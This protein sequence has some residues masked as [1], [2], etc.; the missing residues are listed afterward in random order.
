[1]RSTLALVLMA[2]AA[3][4]DG[5]LVDRRE[6]PMT[7]SFAV[8][9]HFVR[10]SIDEQ[11]AITEV[12]QVLRN[13]SGHPAEAVYL[14]PVPHGA[15]ITGFEMWVGDRKMDGEIM[16]AAK[17]RELYHSFVRTKRDPALLEYVGQGVYRTSVFPVGVDEEKRLRI[18]YTELLKKENGLVRYLYPLNTEKF[19]KFPLEEAKVEVTIKSKGKIKTVYSPSHT[20]DLQRASETSARAAWSVRRDTPRTDFE[21]LYSTDES[22]VG[23]NLLTYRP[24][25]DEPGYFL[26]LASPAATLEGPVE[27][28]DIVFVL[29]KSG[30]MRADN[31]MGQAKEA[32]TFCLRSLND[33]DRF[34]IVSFSSGVDKYTEKLISFNEAEKEKATQH[35]SRI[36]VQGGTNINDA[37]VQALT[38]FEKGERLKMIIFLTDGLPTNGV[39]DVQ[40]IVKNV[41]AANALSVR[42]FNFGV[43]YDVNTT[44]LD[45]L[46]RENKGDSDY[47]K[48][49]ENIEEK[50]SAFYTKVQSP[51]LSS[52]KLDWGGVKVKDVLPRTIPDLFKGGQVVVT[53]RYEGAGPQM[54][55]L[56]GMSRGKE[57]R[58]EVE[59]TFDA[60]SDGLAKFFIERLWA[61]RKIG[62]IIDQIQL[63]GKAQEL[64][65]EIVR[66]SVKYGIITEYTSFLIRED[67]QLGDAK[68]NARRAG[69]EL[70]K[71]EKADGEQGNR[72]ATAKKELQAADKAA[73]PAAGAGFG[74]YKDEHGKEVEAKTVANVGRRTFFQKKNVWQEA[75]VPESVQ[76]K[77][78]KFYSDEFFKLLEEHPELNLIAV[79]DGDVIVKVK[80]QHVKLAK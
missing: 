47:V 75:D 20:V 14:F 53:G 5:L 71:L 15:N 35:V 80:D 41:T 45:K 42:L 49:K 10:V 61:Q 19:S 9:N 32:L 51:V 64:V 72:Q 60:K 76:A 73:A 52:L 44:L 28:K 54:L 8:K 46:A 55:V 36:E 67:V 3:H 78:V 69:E 74:K 16:D 25:A 34:G 30:S 4:A 7:D 58:F 11:Y 13:V 33:G 12:D 65:D 1:M 31:K 27:P 6:R 48:P 18:K 21:I 17:A 22:V 40:S 57:R 79:L 37:L 68:G 77:E 66:I 23:M 29:D 59:G 56:T 38:L 50:V 63:Y 26:L 62:D 24:V 43:G 2:A 39:T 70:R